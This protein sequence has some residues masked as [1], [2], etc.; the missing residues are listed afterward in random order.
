[1]YR[2]VRNMLIAEV[3]A[4]AVLGFFNLIPFD[5]FAILG[6]A[7]V[8]VLLSYLSNAV[9]AAFFHAPRHSESAIITGLILSLIIAPFESSRDIPVLLLAPAIAMAGKYLIAVRKQHIFNPAA[10][11]VVITTFVLGTGAS[12]WVGT[13]WM[14][15]VILACGFFIIHKQRRGTMTTVFV[16]V[17]VLVMLGWAVAKD[18]PLWDML[19][20]TFTASPVLFF[21]SVMLVE[22]VTM[23]ATQ[24]LRIAYAALAGLFFL[25]NL[26]IG[27][28]LVTPELALVIANLVFFLVNSRPRLVLHLKEKIALAPGA[29]EFVFSGPSLTFQPGQYMEWTLQHSHMDARGM[30]RYFTIASSP[31]ERDFRIGVR[32]S[33]KG[34]TFK[35]ALQAMKP[36]EAIVASQRDGD[37]TLPKNPQ[38]PLVFVAGGIGITPF[39]S[40]IRYLLDTNDRRPVTLFAACKTSKDIVY[41]ALFDEA[42]EKIGMK[43]YYLLDAEQA[44]P[45]GDVYIPG[46]LSPDVIVQHV[47]NYEQCVY[48][49][50]GPQMM[51]Q[52]Y[53]KLI[54]GM[55]IPRS[56]IKIDYFPGYA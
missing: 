37:F 10:S 49:L 12:W 50:S 41:K 47:P 25:P 51:V 2:V 8:L 33:E 28:V 4:A 54:R 34:S 44:L 3:G 52:A 40:M 22:P 11:A 29:F 5:G 13:L 42:Q 31:T 46:R 24:R 35:R 21:A 39:R 26:R 55:G 9:L 20:S 6:S 7:V 18:R 45:S 32:F 53:K 15:P 48:Y 16:A 17:S 30:R 56:H 36:G 14:T 38:Q 27:S 43:T 1:M 19:Q 23:P